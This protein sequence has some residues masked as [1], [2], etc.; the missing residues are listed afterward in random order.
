VKGDGLA[1]VDDMPVGRCQW[2]DDLLATPATAA[3]S[4]TSVF[5]RDIEL[6]RFEPARKAVDEDMLEALMLDHD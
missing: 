5:D 6:S 4:D 1:I 2:R 3:V